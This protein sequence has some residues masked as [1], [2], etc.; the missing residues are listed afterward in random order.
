MKRY[1]RSSDAYNSGWTKEYDRELG[2]TYYVYEIPRCRA[3]VE[4]F[5]HDGDWGWTGRIF[6]RG[7]DSVEKNFYGDGSL[8]D[9]MEWAE[10][11]L[12]TVSP[13]FALNGLGDVVITGDATGY[14]GTIDIIGPINRFPQRLLKYIRNIYLHRF[15]DDGTPIYRVEYETDEDHLFQE[16]YDR[17]FAKFLPPIERAGFEIIDD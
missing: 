3:V 15:D 12:F 1:I 8:D 11:R 10:D 6:R 4:E 5:N 13:K 14:Q 2:H 9:A 7:E 16:N 17:F